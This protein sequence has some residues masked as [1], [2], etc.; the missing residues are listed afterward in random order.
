M[1]RWFIIIL[2]ALALM[3]GI[4]MF[5]PSVSGEAFQIQGHTV[6]WTMLIFCGIVLVFHNA[7]KRGR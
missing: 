5:A 4:H 7:L 1:M 6:T 2:A 3:W